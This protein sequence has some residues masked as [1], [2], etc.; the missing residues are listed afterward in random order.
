MKKVIVHTMK[1]NFDSLEVKRKINLLAEICHYGIQWNSCLPDTDKIYV[2]GGIETTAHILSCCIVQWFGFESCGTGETR[3]F[4]QMETAA[5]LQKDISI[6]KWERRIEKYLKEGVDC[7][8][9]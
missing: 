2:L 6:E 7:Q 1:L 5:D 8:E 3:D 9:N 4:L